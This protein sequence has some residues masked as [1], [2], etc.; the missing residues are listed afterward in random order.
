MS[1]QGNRKQV[2]PSHSGHWYRKIAS[3]AVSAGAGVLA[4][5]Q[6]AS[7]QIVVYTPNIS[8]TGTT[9]IPGIF[10]DFHTGTAQSTAFN[11]Y[12][13]SVGRFQASAAVFYARRGTNNGLNNQVIG[14]SNAAGQFPA[15]LLQNAPIAPAAPWLIQNAGIFQTLAASTGAGN[16]AAG[17]PTAFLG[18]RFSDDGVNYN[19]GWAEITIAADFN[20]TLSRFAYDTVANE[21]ILAGQTS[22][23]PEP[24]STVLLL[25]GAAGMAAY[26]KRR[27][28]KSEAASENATV[29]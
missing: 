3:A 17:G 26:R 25:M 12:Q 8:T 6:E 20:V 21:Q 29:A 28:A 22:S 24:S 11:G 2:R 9:G 16:W 14:N 5:P 23:V 15:R 27:A 7:A 18:M 13:F 4:T 1:M 19:Y 10:F